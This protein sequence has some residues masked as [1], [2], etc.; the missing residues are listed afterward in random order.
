M[1]HCHKRQIPCGRCLGKRQSFDRVCFDC[2]GTKLVWVYSHCCPSHDKPH[3]ERVCYC[4]CHPRA[5][6][7]GE[8]AVA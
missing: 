3:P 7:A 6:G 1:K 5:A 8:A 4:P 2:N